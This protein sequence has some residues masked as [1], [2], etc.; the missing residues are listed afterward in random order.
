MFKKE[1]PKKKAWERME[2]LDNLRS[3]CKTD[4]TDL[5]GESYADE[6]W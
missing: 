1:K 5:H 3:I 4:D 6:H 2:I